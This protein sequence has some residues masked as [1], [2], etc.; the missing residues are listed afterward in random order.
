MEHVSSVIARLCVT[1]QAADSHDEIAPI[2]E[3]N[4]YP[5]LTPGTY[6]A[7]CVR[8]KI[9]KDPQFHCWKAI[10]WYKL[11]FGGQEV[12]GFFHLG[13][14]DK[15]KAGPRSEYKR[16][17]TI[18]NG[19]PPRKRQELSPRAF[20]DKVFDVEIG[21]VRKRFDGQE[22][23]KCSVYSTVKKILLRTYP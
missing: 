6:Q 2:C 1:E 22:H 11:P 15:P 7:Q 9:Y 18:A 16:A 14:G 12:C 20:K 10:L 19:G 13:N 23:P 17:W 3:E 5:R 8:G 21:D 4:P